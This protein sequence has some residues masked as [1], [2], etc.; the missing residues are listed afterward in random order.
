MELQN[1]ECGVMHWSDLAQERYMWL[2]LVN[3]V[4]NLRVP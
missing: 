4:T 3:A 1:V 2:A